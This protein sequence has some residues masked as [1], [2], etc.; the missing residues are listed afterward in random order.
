MAHILV[1]MVC[2]YICRVYCAHVYYMRKAG[3]YIP[4]YNVPIYLARI[5][6]TYWCVYIAHIFGLKIRPEDVA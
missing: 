6:V 3:A 5:S 1:R 4:V 2:P